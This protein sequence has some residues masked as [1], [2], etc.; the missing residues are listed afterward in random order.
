MV[1]LNP[2]RVALIAALAVPVACARSQEPTRAITQEDSE[3]VL[4]S[5]ARAGSTIELY[6][7]RGTDDAVLGFAIK[8]PHQTAQYF[9]IY[10]STYRGMPS[11]TFDV[12]VS[13]D[14]TQMWIRSSWKG[15]ETLAHHRFG[16]GTCLTAYGDVSAIATPRPSYLSGGPSPYPAMPAEVHKVLSVRYADP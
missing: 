1:L 3:S 7:A 15:Y 13:N 12:Y 16:A 5:F 10:G 2:T 9:P 14:D 11:A 6:V 8:K 4:G